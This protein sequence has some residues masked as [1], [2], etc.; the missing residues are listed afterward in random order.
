MYVT[1]ALLIDEEPTTKSVVR[2]A[3][4]SIGCTDVKAVALRDA[5]AALTAGPMPDLVVVHMVESNIT[6]LR[7]LHPFTVDVPLL[8]I[9]DEDDVDVAILAGAAECVARPVRERE[10]ACRIRAAVRDRAEAKHRATRERK[11]SDAIAALQREKHVLERLVCVDTLTGVANRRHTLALLAAEWRRSA[12]D[13][14]SVAL[15]MLDLD[16]YHTYNE[17]YGHLGGDACLQ[18]VTEAMVK[19]LRRPSDFLGRYGGEE[20]IAV[21]P[22]TNAA[23]ARIVAERLRGTVE[24]LGIPH[25]ASSC[26]RVVTV[27]AGFAAMK[28][29][30]AVAMETVIALADQALLRA[31]ARGR[32][33]IGGE[34]PSVVPSWMPAQPWHRYAP[35]FA[36]PWFA[37]RIPPFLASIHETACVVLDGSAPQQRPAIAKLWLLK[38]CAHELG[39]LVV[40]TLLGDVGR[41]ASA[42]EVA[43]ARRTAEQ[44]IEYVEHVQVVYR[45]A[46]DS[47]RTACESAQTG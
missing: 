2:D 31:K 47:P 18:R 46:V 15:V 20:F 9:C 13:D 11:L 41:A 45:R 35:V 22:N 1:T 33:C 27:T 5:Q 29:T 36:D 44:L 38:T 43:L 8:A 26:A 3:L 16:C 14:L 7:L 23:G 10:L 4:A 12:R 30:A 17:T 25:T 39:L 6:T 19:C 42:G 34:A 28:P 32:N 21:L 24:A 37:D 40:E